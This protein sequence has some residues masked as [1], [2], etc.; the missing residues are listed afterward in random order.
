MSHLLSCLSYQAHKLLAAS[1]DDSAMKKDNCRAGANCRQ[2]VEPAAYI[3]M[4]LATSVCSVLTI[5][6]AR[7]PL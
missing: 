6:C 1:P 7:A 4:L 5:Q 3:N 2:P